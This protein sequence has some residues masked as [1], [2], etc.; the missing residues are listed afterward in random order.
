MILSVDHKTH[1]RMKLILST[2]LALF[3]GFALIP[4]AIA[5]TNREPHTERPECCIDIR[6]CGRRDCN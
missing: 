2:T 5:T 4:P 6:G 3:I 1:K